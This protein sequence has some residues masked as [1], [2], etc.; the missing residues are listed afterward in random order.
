MG[1]NPINTM[2]QTNPSPSAVQEQPLMRQT[3]KPSKGIGTM[4][5]L[6]LLIPYSI[7]A[8]GTAG[9]LFLNYTK[10]QPH[11]LENIPESDDPG[12]NPKGASRRVS[13]APTPLP[14]HLRTRLGVSISVGDLTV[15]PE[16]V[17]QRRIALYGYN[18]G[19]DPGQVLL[20][21][22]EAL[23]LTLKVKNNSKNVAFA[24]NDPAFNRAFDRSVKANSLPVETAKR[25][26]KKQTAY[27]P[28]VQ[29]GT[30]SDVRPNTFLQIGEDKFSGPFNLNYLTAPTKQRLWLEGFENDYTPLQ[31]GQERL[32]AVATAFDDKRLLELSKSTQE[33][34]LWRVMLRRGIV[35]YAGR[36]IRVCCVIGVEFAA[37]EITRRS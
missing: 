22:G 19:I 28:N 29:A 23:V 20:E 1:I 21:S 33:R 37:N 30:T 4:L 24:P 10:K 15:T 17:E 26:D 8:T 16:R 6:A 3:P 18:T 36:D 12:V 9:I 13:Y 7:L 34:M 11:P 2:G 25:K 35:E 14:D 5:L 31:P 27:R 32:T